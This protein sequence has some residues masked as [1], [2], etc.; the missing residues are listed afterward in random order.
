[1]SGK[2]QTALI[3]AFLACAAFIPAGAGG[4][5][6]SRPEQVIVAPLKG[7]VNPFSADFIKTAIERGGRE[8]AEAVI[9]I[10]DTPGGLLNSTKEI[11]QDI[12]NS[13]VPVVAYISPSGATATSAGTF[14]FLAAHIAAMAPGTSVG[15]AHPVTMQGKAEEGKTGEKITN[16][17]SSYIDSIARQRKRNR[18]W[19][20]KAVTESSSVTWEYAVKNNISDLTAPDMD[21]LLNKIDGMEVK[22]G[23]K[24]M[25]LATAGAKILTHKMTARQKMG[26]ILGSPDIAY[27]LLSLGSI[28]ILMEI[29]NPGSIF[30]G[31]VGA[32]SLMLA[33][34]ALQV[35]PFNYAG[36]GLIM[37]GTGLMIAEVFMTSYGLLAL[38]GLVSLIAGGTLL[39]DPAQTGG[40]NEKTLAT[41][42]TAFVL[43]FGAVAISVARSQKTSVAGGEG[44]VAGME[45]KVV[46]WNGGGGIV[47]IGGEYWK[48]ESNTP[49]SKGERII[50][51][52][53]TK[54]LKVK[55]KR[56]DSGNS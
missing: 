23:G 2:A 49:L 18:K 50:V 54:G 7:T 8:K 53:K 27:L 28:G 40:V 19:A 46:D 55:V 45:G 9:V 43:I 44:Q 4:E 42:G 6:E 39:F 30:P 41:V 15:A 48:A 20:V 51:E 47:F 52:K 36:L 13:P 34:A 24:T 31:V 16:F 29:Y 17:A 26:N 3:C 38:A 32:I 21:T 37:V 10:I 25:K 11:V 35:L 56:S 12:L 14:I 33:F 1:M 22:A 5:T